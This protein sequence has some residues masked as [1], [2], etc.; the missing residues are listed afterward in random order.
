MNMAYAR[1]YVIISGVIFS[2]NH[3][4]CTDLKRA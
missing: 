1:H 3:R 4:I 2:C